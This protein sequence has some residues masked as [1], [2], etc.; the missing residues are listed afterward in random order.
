M[1]KLRH[2]IIEIDSTGPFDGSVAFYDKEGDYVLRSYSVGNSTIPNINTGRWKLIMYA[3][4]M[5]AR[6]VSRMSDYERMYWL[7]QGAVLMADDAYADEIEDL[8]AA[9]LERYDSDLDA[10]RTALYEATWSM[11]K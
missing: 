4:E 10:A 2:D 9:D 5:A 1:S 3:A 8:S 6:G 7:A 11:E